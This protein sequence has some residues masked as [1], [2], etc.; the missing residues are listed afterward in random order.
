MEIFWKAAVAVLAQPV[1]GVEGGANALD[2]IAD[3]FVFGG[4]GEVHADAAVAEE[5]AGKRTT[6]SGDSR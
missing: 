6:R 2:G 5:A 3:L 1:V 4:K